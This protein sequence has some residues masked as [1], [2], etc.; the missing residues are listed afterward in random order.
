MRLMHRAC[1]VDD[2]ADLEGRDG[3]WL[4]AL[5]ADDGPVLICGESGTGKEH[6]AKKLA[7]K[8]G[9]ALSV[10]DLST[11][12]PTVMES[13]LFGHVAGAYTG[14]T[15]DRPGMLRAAVQRDGKRPCWV[16]LDEVHH[17]PPELQAKLLLRVSEREELTPV[18]ADA[19]VK[20]EGVRFIVGTS[21]E[22]SAELK[23]E[24]RARLQATSERTDEKD[25]W[26]RAT[27]G[28][29]VFEYLKE[30]DDPQ[31]NLPD[32][33]PDL[34]NRM[35]WVVRLKPWRDR[36]WESRRAT[37]VSLL[38][39]KGVDG[40]SLAWADDALENPRTFANVRAVKAHVARAFA[41]MKTLQE[42]APK[43]RPT[44]AKKKTTAV[45]LT[46]EER[47]EIANDQEAAGKLTILSL[48]SSPPELA[49]LAEGPR[50]DLALP[51]SFGERPE[52]GLPAVFDG[53]F[54]ADRTPPKFRTLDQYR[55][56][57][58]AKPPEA[59]RGTLWRSAQRYYAKALLMAGRGIKKRMR[60]LS[61]LQPN[62][63]TELLRLADTCE[64][65]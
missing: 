40:V 42:G 27:G 6:V 29:S 32:L 56:A 30:K 43:F 34:V 57:F 65:E 64:S 58:D 41:A 55:Q 50:N 37:I 45:L 62:R 19:P 61:G 7:D 31:I 23:A 15:E 51:R 5:L 14:A 52:Y 17:L 54:G 59:T 33:L 60:E 36:S 9:A 26:S 13:E 22:P 47:A 1:N 3:P 11:L 46:P 24:R 28:P 8:G 10:L 25:A 38:E 48:V 39:G 21:K 12:S 49:E 16:F 35:T 4:A 2:F 63:L 53:D 18:G 20:L 44:N